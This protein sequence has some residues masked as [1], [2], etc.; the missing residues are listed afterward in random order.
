MNIEL[1]ADITA[2]SI[3]L[4]FVLDLLLGDPHWMYHPVRLIGALISFLEKELRA[5]FPKTPRGEVAAGGVMALLVCGAAGITVSAL[6]LLSSLLGFWC[7]LVCRTILCYW[8]F[9]L[10]SLRSRKSWRREIFP[11]QGRRFP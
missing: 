2:L 7:E 3:L 10:R 5:R 1:T 8:L 4:G 11:E 9:A 6:T